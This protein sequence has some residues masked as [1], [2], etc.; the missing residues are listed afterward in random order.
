MTSLTLVCPVCQSTF[1]AAAGLADRAHREGLQ[2]AL[3]LWP[4]ELQPQVLGYLGLFKP[5]Q[6]ALS[7]ARLARVLADL[8]ALLQAGTV[9]RH[10]ETR[11]APLAAWGAGLAAVLKLQDG[12]TLTLPLTSHALLAEIVH[13]DA[14]QRQSQDA[15]AHRPLHPSHRPASRPAADPSPSPAP[16][17]ERGSPPPRD[18]Q[19][20]QAG[21]V[22]VGTLAQA[23]KGRLPAPPP[24]LNPGLTV[25]LSTPLNNETAPTQ[26]TLN[27][28]LTAPDASDNDHE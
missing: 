5:A 23:L 14:G 21:L 22:Q 26:P 25:P 2:A 12:G 28:G 19:A 27:P 10:R 4:A 24:T 18:S 6:R 13:R 3:A 17:G 1:P 15:A 7:P 20:R 16:T 9:T 11:P 8:V